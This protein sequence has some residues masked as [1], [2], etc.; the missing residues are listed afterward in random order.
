MS[1]VCFIEE[2]AS[3]SPNAK[4]KDAA[5]AAG[6]ATGGGGKDKRR[7][8]SGE[9]RHPLEHT[10]AHLACLIIIIHIA[11]MHKRTLEHILRV[12]LLVTYIA[13]TH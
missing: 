11:M 12:S 13:V 6:E 2:P 1:D 8:S 5:D 3:G 10:R 4:D 7:S 9:E